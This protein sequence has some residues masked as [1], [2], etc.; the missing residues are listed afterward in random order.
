L[1]NHYLKGV[2]SVWLSALIGIFIVGLLYVIFSYVLFGQ[3]T[4]V[5]YPQIQA[6]NATASGL[7]ST[8]LDNTLNIISTV[9]M[10]FPLI[11]IFGLIFWAFVASQ[12]TEYRAQYL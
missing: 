9:W 7:N 5:I 2:A 11:F 10:L 3:I 4:P 8:Q 1:K 12:K 6:I